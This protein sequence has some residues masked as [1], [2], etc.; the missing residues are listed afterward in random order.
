MTVQ[1]SDPYVVT[2]GN[3]TSVTFG[4][5]FPAASPSYVFGRVGGVVQQGSTVVLNPDQSNSPGGNITFTA[6]PDNGVEVVVYR[7]T[8]ASQQTVY[9]TQGRF[10]AK[11]TEQ[12]LDKQMMALQEQR[13]SLD[14]SLKV[15]VG[16][17]G[18][19]EVSGDLVEDEILIMQSDTIKSSGTTIGDLN[20]SI[21]AANKA[22]AN[23]GIIIVGDYAT[24]TEL[25]A[26]NEGVTYTADGTFWRPVSV[27]DLPFQIDPVTYPNPADHVP[28]LKLYGDVN[29]ENVGKYSDLVFASV[30]DMQAGTLVDGAQITHGLNRRLKVVQADVVSFY[31][32]T[33]TVTPILLAGGLYAQEVVSVPKELSNSNLF[34]NGDFSVAQ[35][36]RTDGV[37]WAADRWNLNSDGDNASNFNPL[38]TIN[39]TNGIPSNVSVPMQEFG[40]ADPSSGFCFI[41]Q[42]I[43][44]PWE[45]S[46]ATVTMSGI[47]HV[48]DINHAPASRNLA[49][50]YRAGSAGSII[51]FATITTN[52]TDEAVYFS[53]T[54]TLPDMSALMG[55]ANE[56]LRFDIINTA[57]GGYQ[58]N[59]R[60]LVANFKL[61]R[62]PVAT[63]FV[64]DDPAT[65]LAKCQRYYRV[66]NPS[67]RAIITYANFSAG[68]ANARFR[69]SP[70]RAIGSTGI[71]RANSTGF[72]AIRTV[73]DANVVDYDVP[74]VATLQVT[75]SSLQVT[76]TG[77]TN[78]PST[79]IPAH[80]YVGDELYYVDT[81]L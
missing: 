35:R 41:R 34:I 60:T 7:V 75:E 3:G 8:E 9:P 54:V 22:A 64:P 74:S 68:T 67:T 43:E 23:A 33:V 48:R 42:L 81:E 55:N 4:F 63:P 46:N 10:P 80:V 38:R 77:V 40:N 31:I 25:K 12:A 2:T 53:A 5:D 16:S 69:F 50:R 20:D 11:A 1:A 49:L 62:G 18:R 65:N 72:A 73:N 58:P 19:Y 30:A 17:E 32:T 28:Q 36:G 70:M 27:S 66:V 52:A 24:G 57:S 79:T 45:Y 59:D 21:D 71:Y 6:P 61:E 15:P 29:S 78:W 51:G 37:E 39:S 76:W 47:V 26:I 13:D 56:Y 14:R 44:N